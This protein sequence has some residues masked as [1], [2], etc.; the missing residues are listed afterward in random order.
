MSRCISLNRRRL[1]EYTNVINDNNTIRNIKNERPLI[2]Q[3][4]RT[5]APLFYISKTPSIRL[6]RG[7]K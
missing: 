1:E 3:I 5:N 7:M 2:S 4:E 6:T